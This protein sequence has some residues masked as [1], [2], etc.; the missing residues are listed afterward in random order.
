MSLADTVPRAR[1]DVAAA[2]AVLAALAAL[3]FG[4]ASL[5]GR[6]F[7][8]S[9]TPP[10]RYGFLT[11]A[12]TAG[13]LHLKIPADPALLA[14][15]D[16]W[17]PAQNRPFRIPGATQDASLYDGR[18]YYYFG[19]A[20]VVTLFAPFRLI[21]GRYLRE[22]AAVPLFALALV[23]FAWAAVRQVVRHS[24]W[25]WDGVRSA[26]VASVIGLT[27]LLAFACRTPETY[28]T[29]I[30][31]GASFAAAGVFCLSR[32][33][34][35]GK[36]SSWMLSA[37]GLA[38]G[39]AFASR[40]THATDVVLLALASMHLVR[41]GATSPVFARRRATRLLALWTPW[42][43]V[44]A[45]VLIHN[46]ARFGR[47]G[48]FGATFALSSWPHRTATH[49][50]LRFIPV[51]LAAYLVA[52]PQVGPQFPFVHLVPHGLPAR[53]TG[54]MTVEGVAGIL[55]CVPALVLLPG[56]VFLAPRRAAARAMAAAMVAQAAAML[57][58]LVC[59]RW[60]AA[61]YLVDVLPFLAV[62]AAIGGCAPM[63]GRL[64]RVLRVVA[65]ALLAQAVAFN[66]GVGLTGKFD[67]VAGEF[68]RR[69]EAA[70]TP[71][72]RFWLRHADGRYGDVA[73]TLVLPELGEGAQQTLLAVGTVYRRDVLCVEAVGRRRVAF[74]LMSR[75]GEQLR[76]P[77]MR[78]RRGE[79]HAV[80]I[81]MGA[82][83]PLDAEAMA[84]IWPPERVEEWRRRFRIR[85]DGAE[86]LA[87]SY[88][89]RPP[90]PYV[91]LG[92]NWFG[93][94]Y[95]PAAFSGRI[96]DVRR[97]LPAPVP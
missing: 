68:P 1:A 91:A 4:C 36:A 64:A 88:D 13:Q 24:G 52:A 50:A 54:Y 48:E 93:P 51:N 84:R 26:T 14:L 7:A 10:D 87:A 34:C 73:M 31:A 8:L 78:L 79:P 66:L 3:Y 23:A 27:P 38:L 35:G 19:P 97:R 72:Q 40:P 44:A 81:D 42:L 32:A 47:L 60:A 9:E 30:V 57:A 41:G 45:L 86:I 25:P 16:P 39:L 46:A 5:A 12:W 95:C 92:A 18:L 65:G 94:D 83:L 49:L 37:A 75:G 82:L 17:D 20:P 53:P 77:P 61:R 6:P 29:A 28:E 74:V 55:W 71:W 2:V 90:S 43:V 70:A 59:F 89:F 69:L 22:D 85:V 21:T 67:E 56:A 63:E 76:T 33:L 58:L 80:E 62:A 96:T 11:E 15:S